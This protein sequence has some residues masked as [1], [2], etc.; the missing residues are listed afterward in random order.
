MV[1]VVVVIVLNGGLCVSATVVLLGQP[2][3]HL[4]HLHPFLPWH[5]W[6]SDGLQLLLD[7]G[8]P[9]LTAW[10]EGEPR[11]CLFVFWFLTGRGEHG[12]CTVLCTFWYMWQIKAH[13][14]I[15]SFVE[16]LGPLVLTVFKA[17]LGEPHLHPRVGAEDHRSKDQQSQ[18]AGVAHRH[19]DCW[20]APRKE[21]LLGT[22]RRTYWKLGGPIRNNRENYAW[23][24]E[25]SPFGPDWFDGGKHSDRNR[26][27]G[28]AADC[29]IRLP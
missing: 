23:N 28:S 26:G 12:D 11:G 27:K 29:L 25:E 4:P 5:V 2:V 24:T 22:P 21:N 9:N 15:H 16:L 6:D 20:G 10:K 17:F 19:R 18:A 7:G 3:L 13:S 8:H 1:V 14:F